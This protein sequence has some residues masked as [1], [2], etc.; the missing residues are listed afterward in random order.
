MW[1]AATELGI[2]VANAPGSM[3]CVPVAEHAMA[4][5]LMM[6]RRPWLWPTGER[7]LHFQLQ[8]ATLGIVG[9]GNIGQALARRAAAFEM[10]ICAYTRTRGKFKPVGFEVEEV[11][12]L[13]D[14][15]AARRFR[16]AHPP[17]HARE[18][19]PDR[20][21]GTRAHEGDGV[22]HQRLARPPRGF[23]RAHRRHTRGENRRRGPRRGRAG[24]PS[25]E[26]IPSTIFPT[27]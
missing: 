19:G 27:W 1:Q 20:R 13:G 11:D 24:P 22:S 12:T 2:P 5:T 16:G 9:L 10:E 15:L 21:T 17:P 7:R 26:S 14:L 4:L 23:R 3:R 25:R 6:A 18:H 8:G